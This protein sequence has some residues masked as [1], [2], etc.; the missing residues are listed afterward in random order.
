MNLCKTP[1]DNKRKN[2]YQKR[3]VGQLNSFFVLL[4]LLFVLLGIRMNIDG[5][6]NLV[7]PVGMLLQHQRC[8]FK[9]RASKKE[10]NE[11]AS[12]L[13]ADCIRRIH[14]SGSILAD[15]ENRYILN[16]S[17]KAELVQKCRSAPETVS[18][19]NS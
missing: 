14:A 12:I 4:R 6:L 11:L 5:S 18:T 15:N 10:L 3:S 13:N 2:L 8:Y 19:N 17:L 9:L 16:A 7:V 1:S